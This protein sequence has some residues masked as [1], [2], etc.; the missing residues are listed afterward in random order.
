[1]STPCIF[2]VALSGLFT[3]QHFQVIINKHMKKKTL[4]C[5]LQTRKEKEEA[6]E[7]SVEYVGWE[8]LVGHY[9][10]LGYSVD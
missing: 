10:D 9:S 8:P 1:M 4:P 3:L 2:P 5:V 7:Q 6:E